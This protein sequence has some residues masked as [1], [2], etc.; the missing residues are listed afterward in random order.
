MGRGA[1]RNRSYTTSDY[2]FPHWP[3][4]LFSL[5]IA[6]A[7][8]PDPLSP[9]PG[10]GRPDEAATRFGIEATP[11]SISAMLDLESR[12]SEPNKKSNARKAKDKRKRK[13]DKGGNNGPIVGTNGVLTAPTAISGMK[14][15][16]KDAIKHTQSSSV[17]YDPCNE[18]LKVKPRKKKR[19][20]Q[21]IVSKAPQKSPPTSESTGKSSN[22]RPFQFKNGDNQVLV[23]VDDLYPDGPFTSQLEAPARRKEAFQPRIDSLTRAPARDDGDRYSC[24]E[25]VQIVELE[26]RG[27]LSHPERDGDSV[28]APVLSVVA[29]QELAQLALIP[30]NR[31]RPPVKLVHLNIA[32]QGCSSSTAA[33]PSMSRQCWADQQRLSSEPGGAC[34]HLEKVHSTRAYSSNVTAARWEEQYSSSGSTT[35]LECRSTTLPSEQE[36]NCPKG[37]HPPEVSGEKRRKLSDLSVMSSPTSSQKKLKRRSLRPP[38]SSTTTKRVAANTS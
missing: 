11:H 32:P 36:G 4:S 9:P 1:V 34:V 38:S 23:T 31:I 17:L 12:A 15:N 33:D 24:S 27:S 21:V 30:V 35:K 8:P 22:N 2:T 28:I 5:R 16:P 20:K 18:V 13:L 29:D 37:S 10:K 6:V 7:Q 14:G 19:V 26:A 3:L 25:Y